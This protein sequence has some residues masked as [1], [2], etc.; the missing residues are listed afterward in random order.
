MP[1]TN[2]E[3]PFNTGDAIMD[4]YLNYCQERFL[5]HRANASMA[6]S[7]YIEHE[8]IKTIQRY[9]SSHPI[10]LD[11]NYLLLLRDN[12][13]GRLKDVDRIELCRLIYNAKQS[14]NIIFPYTHTTFQE[15]IKQ[16]D[17]TTRSATAQVV[18]ELSQGIVI[19]P[20]VLRRPYEYEMFL[21]GLDSI[22]NRE[23]FI[24]A[25][26]GYAL[27]L[28]GEL[29]LTFPNNWNHPD[30]DVFKKV[31]FDFNRSLTLDDKITI[32]VKNSEKSELDK[33]SNLFTTLNEGKFE[34]QNPEHN[35]NTILF[36]ELL[37]G[38]SGFLESK[39]VQGEPN[40]W[41]ARTLTLNAMSHFTKCPHT[42]HLSSDRIT[43]ALHAQL[44]HERNQ[45]YKPTD[46]FDFAHAADAIPYCKAFFTDKSLQK[47]LCSKP[48]EFNHLFGCHIAS[49]IEEPTQ[50]LRALLAKT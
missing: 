9:N 29:R 23:L 30:T 38:M 41:L 6:A 17:P 32:Y 5:F 50:Y 48:L 45:K 46:I 22:D 12:K 39:G 44:R 43:A 24:R 10:Y 26:I 40:Q 25:S 4:K 35:Y 28:Y 18:D 11:T 31:I 42:L 20:T 7:D 15:I 13:L 8:K 16:T 3:K 14:T 21:I 19:K 37:S 36:Q 34:H 49:G 1:M 47:R 2:P 33:L 27:E